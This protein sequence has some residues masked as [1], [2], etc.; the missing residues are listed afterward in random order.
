M[1][2]FIGVGTSCLVCDICSNSVFN[3][4][5]FLQ[6]HIEQ[7]LELVSLGN[8]EGKKLIEL[9]EEL[10]INSNFVKEDI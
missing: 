1:T 9:K 2:Q 7:P 8:V 5:F 4:P 6:T 10:L 3:L